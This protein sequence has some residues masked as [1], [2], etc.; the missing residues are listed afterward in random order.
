[1]YFQLNFQFRDFLKFDN[2]AQL[3]LLIDHAWTC[4]YYRKTAIGY[5]T[6]CCSYRQNGE[7]TFNFQG[8]FA[9]V[10]CC[11]SERG[12]TAHYVDSDLKYIESTSEASSGDEDDAEKLEAILGTVYTSSP[13]KESLAPAER[14]LLLLFDK[15]CD[16]AVEDL[17]SG[18]HLF[19]CFYILPYT[20]TL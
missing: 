4:L 15:E 13:V 11:E 16:F 10:D 12:H 9:E 8:I 7:S 5:P 14:Q 2:H 17:E 6:A 20:C 3:Y 1:L 19:F 18:I